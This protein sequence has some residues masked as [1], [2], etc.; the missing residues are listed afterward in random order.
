MIN[1]MVYAHS[2]NER[3]YTADSFFI[4]E[5]VRSLGAEEV[6]KSALLLGAYRLILLLGE[7]SIGEGTRLSFSSAPKS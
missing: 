4:N 1:E 3:V 2:I 5:R 6:H 7:V